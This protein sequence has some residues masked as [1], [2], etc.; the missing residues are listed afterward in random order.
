MSQRFNKNLAEGENDTQDPFNTD[1]MNWSG[2]NN[3]CYLCYDSQAYLYFHIEYKQRS[4]TL[5]QLKWHGNC[6]SF[7]ADV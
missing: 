7:Y 1:D 2:D 4:L 5:P 3:F 6:E